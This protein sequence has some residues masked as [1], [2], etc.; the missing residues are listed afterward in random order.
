MTLDMES[1]YPAVYAGTPAAVW[2]RSAGA[3]YMSELISPTP[4]SWGLQVQLPFLTLADIFP[5]F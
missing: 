4:R 1:C 2:N 5:D 3:Y